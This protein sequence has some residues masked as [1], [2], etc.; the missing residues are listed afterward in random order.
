MGTSRAAVAQRRL[1]T[2]SGSERGCVCVGGAG[3]G[4]EGSRFYDG[5]PLSLELL[6]V[7]TPS[8]SPPPMHACFAGARLQD[9]AGTSELQY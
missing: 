3:S 9:K 7:T 4:G 1:S 6:G 2:T 8:G 5:L